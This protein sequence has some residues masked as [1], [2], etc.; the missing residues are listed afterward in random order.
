MRG[1]A[2]TVVALAVL[3]GCGGTARLSKAQY[4][5][6][7]SAIGTRAGTALTGIFSNPAVTNP[8]SLKQVAQVVKHG[9]DTIDQAGSEIGKL[10][11]PADAD[12]DNATL[13]KGFHE[14]ADELRQFST[15][16]ERGDVA[17]VKAFDQQASA[18]T[19]PGER[20][21]QQAVNALKR[22]GY[23]VGTP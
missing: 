15:A 8:S 17:K 22:K 20:V 10:H 13:A 9:A 21:I 4:E 2:A 19:L 1:A 12:A 16:A 11:P 3:V 5:R 23:R 6:Q 7:L 14:L 18:N